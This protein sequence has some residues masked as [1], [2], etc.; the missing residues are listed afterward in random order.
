[1]KPTKREPEKNDQPCQ[2][3]CKQTSTCIPKT[4]LTYLLPNFFPL[5]FLFILI[6][7]RLTVGG[8]VKVRQKVKDF[9]DLL[10]ARGTQ[11]S[12]AMSIVISRPI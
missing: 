8:A 5:L 9:D 1:M 4:A 6:L 10:R 11:H 12:V 3:C 2:I 7:S